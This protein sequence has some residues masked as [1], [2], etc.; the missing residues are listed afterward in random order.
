MV[1]LDTAVV[2]EAVRAAPDPRV[3]AWLNAQ[4]YDTVY[5]CAPTAAEVL[6]G[7]LK[8]PKWQRENRLGVAPEDKILK[9][10]EKRILAFDLEAARAY[11]AILKEV[12]RQGLSI[13]RRQAQVAAV[14]KSYGL[15]VACLDS[16][17]FVRAGVF[18]VEVW[19]C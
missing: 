2:A 18:C 3:I 9:V 12:R 15:R 11:G 16:A 5:I 13:S 1:L 14:A 19:F 6:W 7:C 8:L 10:F 17:P 4:A